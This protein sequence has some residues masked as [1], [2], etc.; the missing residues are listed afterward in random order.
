MGFRIVDMGR[1]TVTDADGATFEAYVSQIHCTKCDEKVAETKVDTALAALGGDAP[2]FR[3]AE[4][5]AF[6]RSAEQA[7]R[8]PKG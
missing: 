8:C 5:R 4:D 1:Q 7:H 2:G 3:A 6:I